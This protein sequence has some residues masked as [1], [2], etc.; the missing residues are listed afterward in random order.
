MFHSAAPPLSSSNRP[1]RAGF[2]MLRACAYAGAVAVLW[3]CTE[4]PVEPRQPAA[5]LDVAQDE[6]PAPPEF[7]DYLGAAGYRYFRGPAVSDGGSPLASGLFSL[8][9]GPAITASANV[10]VNDP[11]GP[12]LGQSEVD[13]A[14]IGSFVVVAWNDAR[15]FFVFNDG[16]SGWGFSADGGKTFTDGGSFPRKPIASFRRRGDPALAAASDAGVF[17]FADICQETGVAALCVTKGTVAGG[18]IT[19]GT[20]VYAAIAPAPAFFLDKEFIAADPTGTN[21]YVTY[22][23]FGPGALGFGQIESVASH[24]GGVTWAAPVV[25]AAAISGT[26]LQ[27]SEPALDQKGTLYVVWEKGWQTTLTPQIVVSKST[28]GGA[29]FSS[30]SVAAT[31]GTLAFNRPIGY[32]RSRIND[33]PR[34]A[35]ATTGKN[36]DDVYVVFH[37]RDAGDVNVFATRS[38]NG[39][40]SWSTPVQLND[41]SGDAQFW[42][43]VMVEPGGN[44]DV[45]WYDRRNNVPGSGLTDV[46]WTQSIDGGTTWRANERV[47]DVSTNWIGI[48]TDIAPNFGDYNGLAT[49]GNRTYAG[50][51]D[52]RNGNPDV[53]FSIIRG[54][55]KSGK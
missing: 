50:W 15:G 44:V 4:A 20:P 33:F 17:F 13:V 3:G 42:P 6:N 31:I 10:Q 7:L 27:G 18:S 45:L 55:G 5:S 53:Y 34:I 21:I 24:D 19:W 43:M 9:A 29:T 22:T 48:A 35:V 30:P 23:R 52:G 47:T 36:K 39:G 12:G 37:S 38:S 26:V 11:A 49:S 46:Y 54:A 40:S 28:D 14:A 2:G 16:L 32:N 8:A 51:G 1:R 25:V 41:A